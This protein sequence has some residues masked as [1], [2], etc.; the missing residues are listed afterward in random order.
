MGRWIDRRRRAALGQQRRRL[1]WMSVFSPLQLVGN[2]ILEIIIVYSDADADGGITSS[3][4]MF[5]PSP[6][7]GLA[8][9][10]GGK[11]SK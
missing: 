8:L 10:F 3:N 1:I 6:K 7:L 11:N 2:V 9:D 5:V 4:N